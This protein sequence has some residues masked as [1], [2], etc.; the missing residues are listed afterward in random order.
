MNILVEK[1]RRTGK[2]TSSSLFGKTE[3]SEE[4]HIE[5][6]RNLEGDA[7]AAESKL[8]DAT[9]KVKLELLEFDAKTALVGD[10]F[11]ILVN[12]MHMFHKEGSVSEKK[13]EI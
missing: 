10:Y 1:L 5:K 2:A 11:R 9:E 12:N 7:D 3:M 4:D 13:F 6:I 8:H